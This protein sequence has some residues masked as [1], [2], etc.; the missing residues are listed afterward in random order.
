MRNYLTSRNVAKLAPQILFQADPF[1][2]LNNGDHTRT[3][4]FFVDHVLVKD[5]LTS[6]QWFISVVNDG[7]VNFDLPRHEEKDPVSLL[8]E[9]MNDGSSLVEDELRLNQHF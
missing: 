9:L 2:R 8:S 3:L 4:L 7:V 5:K 1:T 6:L